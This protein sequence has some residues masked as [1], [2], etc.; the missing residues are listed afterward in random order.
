MPK[1]QLGVDREVG[2]K[3][4]DT[5]QITQ[6]TR[7]IGPSDSGN[8]EVACSHDDDGSQKQVQVVPKKRKKKLSWY[9]ENPS[10][11]LPVESGAVTMNR[12]LM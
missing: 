3:V 8:P 9:H 12:Q 7:M 4:D 10:K 5:R 6:L 11:V 1:H 2:E